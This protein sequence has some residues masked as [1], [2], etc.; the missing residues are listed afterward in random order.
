MKIGKRIGRSNFYFTSYGIGYR[1]T[2]QAQADK[3]NRR[4]IISVIILGIVAVG[5]AIWYCTC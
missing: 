3:L 4:L 2:S 5:L 1:V